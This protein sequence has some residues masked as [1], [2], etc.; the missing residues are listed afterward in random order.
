[1]IDWTW[2]QKDKYDNEKY[3]IYSSMN[4]AILCWPWNAGGITL[5]RRVC[6]QIVSGEK[7]AWEVGDLIEETRHF[8][9]VTRAQARALTR[10]DPFER[11]IGGLVQY[12]KPKKKIRKRTS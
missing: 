12:K 5:M 7:D 11:M 4:I 1:M 2:T 8:W 3:N 6:P 10:R 9:L